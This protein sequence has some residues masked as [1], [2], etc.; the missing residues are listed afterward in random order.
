MIRAVDTVFQRCIC[1]LEAVPRLL[2]C[3]L[4][5]FTLGGGFFPKPFKTLERP[6]SLCRYKAHWKQ[7]LCFVFRAWKTEQPLRQQVYGIRFSAPQEALM[8]QV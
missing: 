5:T 8:E 7:F 1:T 2:R 4:R 3:W 6:A